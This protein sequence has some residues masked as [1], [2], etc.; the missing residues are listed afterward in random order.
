VRIDCFIMFSVRVFLGAD[1]CSDA[2]GVDGADG[3][4][5]VE[6][7]A[8]EG[9]GLLVRLGDGDP[10]S[11]AQVVEAVTVVAKLLAVAA[12]A[13]VGVARLVPLAVTVATA[14]WRAL[15]PEGRVAAEAGPV[16]ATRAL[17]VMVTVAAARATRVISFFM[18]V[19]PCFA[20]CVVRAVNDRRVVP[21][22]SWP[23]RPS[24]VMH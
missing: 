3:P 24:N 23:I 11:L 19:S 1:F 16:T 6:V 15:C 14:L 21:K 2:A 9:V 4:E 10:L 20:R 8:V 7:P 22:G 18:V 12:G 5:L 13:P 17:P